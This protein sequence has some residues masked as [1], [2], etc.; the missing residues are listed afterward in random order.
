MGVS[1]KLDRSNSNQL[2]QVFSPGGAGQKDTAASEVEPAGICMLAGLR[3]SLARQRHRRIGWVLGLACLVLRADAASGQSA[4]RVGPANPDV[5]AVFEAATRLV[6]PAVVEIFAT[7][8][9][10]GGGVA[11]RTSELISTERGSGSGVIVD[12]DGYIVTNAHVVRDAQRLQV[13]LPI[14]ATGRSI[15]ATRSRTVSARI[16]GIDVETDLAVIKVDERQLPA[17]SFGDSDELRAGQLVLAFGSPFG[18]HNSVT[19]GVVSAVA[20][21]LQPESPMIYVQTDAS[22]NPGSSGGPLVDLRGQIV[23]INTL[24]V[25]QSG[26]HE[27]LGF[28]APS[29][30]VRNVYEEI[31]KNGR[32]RRGDIGIRAQTVTPALAAGLDL[33]RTEGVVLADV[34][35]GSPAA[36]AGLRR[37][38]LVLALDGKPMENGRQLQVGLYRRFIG[39][40]VSLEIQRDAQVLKVSVMMTERLDRFAGLSAST[41]PRQNLVPRLGI[42]GVNLDGRIANT[43]GVLRVSSGVVVASTGAGVL[44]ARDGGLV[45]GDVIYAV[46]RTPVSGLAELRAALDGLK[47]GDP[48][49]LHLERGGELIYLAFTIE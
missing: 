28:A 23:G 41:D 15:L 35:P 5:S 32:V 48:V 1:R 27:G 11:S 21:Q 37:G 7:S 4:A 6:T 38:D 24:I 26:A 40:F 43:L 19:L 44:N 17:L 30:I 12:A 47:T 2:S 9:V 20:R 22:I 3:R 45:G 42:L 29:N 49:V 33:P 8:Y 10:P 13:E 36:G 46:N 39:D 18:L 14:A 34:I 25:S 31:S 16:V